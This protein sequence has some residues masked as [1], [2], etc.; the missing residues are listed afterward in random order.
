MFMLMVG[1]AVL[2]IAILVAAPLVA[3]IVMGRGRDPK[4]LTFVLWAV[5]AALLVAALLVRPAS[6]ETSAFPPPPDMVDRP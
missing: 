5:G 6:D 4:G 1:L 2:G 3:R